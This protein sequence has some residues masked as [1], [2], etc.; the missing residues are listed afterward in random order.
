MTTVTFFVLVAQSSEHRA[1]AHH[2]ESIRRLTP[3]RAPTHPACL[4]A[5]PGLAQHS[6]QESSHDNTANT[7]CTRG[8]DRHPTTI[9]ATIPR[10]VKRSCGNYWHDKRNQREGGPCTGASLVVGLAGQQ[11][12][13][14]E[15]GDQFQGLRPSGQNPAKGSLPVDNRAGLP[16]LSGSCLLTI[17]VG[18]SPS[19]T[20]RNSRPADTDDGAKSTNWTRSRR[21][22]AVLCCAGACCRHLH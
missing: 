12:T 1:Q 14:T 19:L 8:I 3:K 5:R 7:P 9:I 22:C 13:T 18:Q 11:P 6:P 21:V 2:G 4:S 10:L 16:D 20:N 17:R 15:R